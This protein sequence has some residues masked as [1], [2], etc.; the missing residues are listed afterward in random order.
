MSNSISAQEP[1]FRFPN[2]RTVERDLIDQSR[3]DA[4]AAELQASL[5]REQG[6]RDEERALSHRQVMLAQEFEHRFTNGLQ[7]I[8][9]VLLLQ[10][11]TMTTPEASIQLSIAARRIDALGHVHHRLQL[12]N[13]VAKVE[14]KQCLIG[15]CDDLSGLLFQN[16][17]GRAIVV[18]GTKVEIP[19]SLASPLGLIATEL[20]T[21]SVKHASGNITVRIENT[22]FDTYS[23]SVLDDGPGLPAGFEAAKSKGLGMKLILWFVKQI[24]G[25]LQIIR[26]DDGHRTCFTVTFA[27]RPIDG[28]ESPI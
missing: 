13:Q 27:G 3:Y 28:G 5:A 18:E 6:L 11:R 9:S 8:A 24:G 15:L 4:L 10:S 20:I 16:R 26:R 25:D 7:L 2:W 17:N 19:S 14:F 23:L 1:L 12:L 22:A 21:N